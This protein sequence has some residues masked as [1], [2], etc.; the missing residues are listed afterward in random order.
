LYATDDRHHVDAKELKRV[1]RATKDGRKLYRAL[2]I[3][4]WAAFAD[5]RPTPQWWSDPAFVAAVQSWQVEARLEPSDEPQPDP[6]RARR[7]MLE[8]FGK[9][10][11]GGVLKSLRFELAGAFKPFVQFVRP[12]LPDAATIRE[13]ILRDHGIEPWS[14]PR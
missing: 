8:S 4:P 11:F 2:G 3:L 1:Q 9:R 10:F 6:E 5:G 12:L 13:R 7:E 14:P